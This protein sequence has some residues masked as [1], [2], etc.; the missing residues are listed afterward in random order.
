[1]K[2]KP[3][4]VIL[5]IVVGTSGFVVVQTS[6]Q[7]QTPDTSRADRLLRAEERQATALE[8]LVRETRSVHTELRAIQRGCR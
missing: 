1:M 6:A 3:W 7:T 2:I 4:M 5:G 8:A